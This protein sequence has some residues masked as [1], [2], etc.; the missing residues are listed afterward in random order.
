M[1]EF[2]VANCNLEQVS[3]YVLAQFLLTTNHTE[4]NYY[5]Q[6]VNAWV[7]GRLKTEDPGKFENFKKFPEIIKIDDE[8]TVGYLK[9]NIDNVLENFPMLV[10]KYSIEKLNLLHFVNLSTIFAQECFR[11]HIFI[12]NSG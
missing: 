9:T 8:C 12:F 2:K 3:F 11:K 4:R 1:R 6:K 10:V 5:H 7:A